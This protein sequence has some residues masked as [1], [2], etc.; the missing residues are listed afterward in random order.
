MKNTSSRNSKL[1]GYHPAGSRQNGFTLIEI[2]IAMALLA[3]VLGTS[4]QIFSNCIDTER[5]VIEITVPEKVGEGILSLIRR[6]LAGAVFKG[7][8]E[9]LNNQVFDG[10]SEGSENQEDDSV[11]FVSTVD[12]TPGGDFMEW[13]NLRTLTVVGYHLKPNQVSSRYPTYTL[14]RKEMIDFAKRDITNAPGLNYSIYDKVKSLRIEYFDGYNWRD[15]WDSRK[16]IEEMLI[17][18]EE[19]SSLAGTRSNIPRVT[20]DVAA[21]EEGLAIDQEQQAAAIPVAVR[22]ELQIYSGSGNEILEKG[23]GNDRKPV[24]NTFTTMVPLLASRR[25]AIPIEDEDLAA[26]G[27]AGGAGGREAGADGAVNTFGADLTKDGRGKGRG[28]GSLRDRLTE[29]G[30]RGASGRGQNPRGRNP[31]PGVKERAMNAVKGAG[32]AAGATRSFGKGSP[33]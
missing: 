1:H 11:Y 15:E 24:V 7:C 19:E 12:P 29:R 14:Y 13:D 9:Q 3:W 22:I 20:G 27:G 28:K 6:D 26:A 30:G 33:R 17:R 31:A 2:V 25:I 5:H 32:G 8:T 4:Y 10:R 18:Q 23:K 21:E 16:N